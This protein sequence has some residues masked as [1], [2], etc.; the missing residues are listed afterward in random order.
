MSQCHLLSEGIGIGME[1]TKAT[2][3]DLNRRI[4]EIMV[5]L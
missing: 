2:L 1:E 4:G 3:A 5:H